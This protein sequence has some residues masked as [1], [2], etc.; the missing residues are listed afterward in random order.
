MAMNE[1]DQPFAQLLEVIEERHL[2]QLGSRDE[3][4]S[5]G[6]RSPRTSGFAVIGYE[7]G[8]ESTPSGVQI[9]DLCSAGS[10]VT[11]V[12]GSDSNWRGP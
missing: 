5:V 4:S 11:G 10:A 2:R 6:R 7:S 3:R 9:G 12:V 1:I 8:F